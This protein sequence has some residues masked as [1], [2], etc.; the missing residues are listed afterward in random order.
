MIRST[1]PSLLGTR[2][3]RDIR[4]ARRIDNISSDEFREKLATGTLFKRSVVLKWNYLKN[5]RETY[6]SILDVLNK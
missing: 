2:L 4:E 6:E 1:V 3:S 5:Y